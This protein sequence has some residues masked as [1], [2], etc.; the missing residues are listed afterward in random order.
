ALGD[1]RSSEEESFANGLLEAPAYTKPNV[2]RDMP[3][4][5]V[6]LSGNHKAIAEWKLEHALERTKTNR[7]DLYE[8]WAAAHPE[9]FSPKKKKKRTKLTHYKPRPEQQMPQD[10]PEN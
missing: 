10:T 6:F 3:V 7:P 1:S 9:H 2:F 4:P 8:A 5:E